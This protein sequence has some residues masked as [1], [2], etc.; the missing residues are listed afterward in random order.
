[1][2]IV[3]WALVIVMASPLGIANARPQQ[4]AAPASNQGAN[5]QEDPLVVAARRARQQKKTETP[6]VWTNDNIPKQGVISVVGNASESA[7][8]P[9][10]SANAAPAAGSAAAS[11]GT[12]AG[13]SSDKGTGQSTGANG[14]TGA[15]GAAGGTAGSGGNAGNNKAGTDTSA[16]QSGLE[17]AKQ[18]LESLKTDLDILQR[19]Y[20]LDQQTYYSKPEY[21]SDKDGAAALQGEDN[22]IQD[23]EQDVEAAQ[24]R[25]DDLQA[26]LQAAGNSGSSSSK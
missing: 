8:A 9:V 15:S 23:K 11:Q 17:E 25:V 24:K 14:A 20:A 12:A 22:Q 13:N 21:Q 6:T 1:M 2:R 10:D 26:Q 4:S 5:Q 19:K 18:K 16:L 3:R 7:P